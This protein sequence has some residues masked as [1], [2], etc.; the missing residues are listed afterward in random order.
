M[1]HSGR[2]HYFDIL[3]IMATF[4]VILLHLCARPWETLSI[5]SPSWLFF[6]GLDSAVRWAVPLFVMLSGALFLNDEK[7]LSFTAICK[8]N[9]LRI[10]CAFLF[11]STVYGFIGLWNGMPLRE[12]PLALLKGEYHMWF[13]FLV[14]GLYLFVPLLRRITGTKKHTE[15]FLAGGGLFFFLIPRIVHLLAVLNI[16]VPFQG[17]ILKAMNINV[18]SVCYLFVF[19]L[20]HYLHRYELSSTLRKLLYGF[21]LLGFLATVSLTFW[22]SRQIGMPSGS[23]Y[24][25]MS[26]PVMAMAVAIF[27]FAKYHWNKEREGMAFISRCSFGMYLAHVKFILPL[28]TA[29]ITPWSV[30]PLGVGVF[31]LSLGVSAVANHIPLLKRYIV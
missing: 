18:V 21:G 15:W 12:F 26:F 17:L 16:S 3:R 25:Y 9:L 27:V 6:N 1:S 8:K 4:A 31:V 19:V 7:E 22:H 28:E 14:M 23:F 10:V 29:W 30:L 5:S 11:W 24:T 20:G 13:L 2:I